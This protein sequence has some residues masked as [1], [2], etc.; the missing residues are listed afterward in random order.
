MINVNYLEETGVISTVTNPGLIDPGTIVI[1]K[2]GS[3]NVPGGDQA[4]DFPVIELDTAFL[5]HKAESNKFLGFIGDL[6][7]YE[8]KHIPEKYYYNNIYPLELLNTADQDYLGSDQ[9]LF[10]AV[11]KY[12]VFSELAGIDYKN[13]SSLSPSNYDKFKPKYFGTVLSGNRT[14]MMFMIPPGYDTAFISNSS[15]IYSYDEYFQ[16]YGVLFQEEY[17]QEAYL[18]PRVSFN[19]TRPSSGH[20]YYG[21]NVSLINSGTIDVNSHSYQEVDPNTFTSIVEQMYDTGIIDNATDP[22]LDPDPNTGGR[23]N[24]T[25][26]GVTTVSSL[27]DGYS[28]VNNSTLGLDLVLADDNLFNTEYAQVS[29]DVFN[30]DYWTP[31]SSYKFRPLRDFE[32]YFKRRT[33]LGRNSYR[34][35]KLENLLSNLTNLKEYIENRFSLESENNWLETEYLFAESNG[36]ESVY[37]IPVYINVNDTYRNLRDISKY[38]FLLDN[39]ENQLYQKITKNGNQNI[40]DVQCIEFKWNSSTGEATIT[41]SPIYGPELYQLTKEGTNYSPTSQEKIWKVDN[42]HLIRTIP[43]NSGLVDTV[44]LTKVGSDFKLSKV[45]ENMSYYK[46]FSVKEVIM[47]RDGNTNE[48]YYRINKPGWMIKVSNNTQGTTPYNPR[49]HESFIDGN[50]DINPQWNNLYGSANYYKYLTEASQLK[51][52]IV[53]SSYDDYYKLVKIVFSPEENYSIKLIEDNSGNNATLTLRPG[54]IFKIEDKIVKVDYLWEERAN[55][56]GNVILLE[57][58]PNSIEE[59]KYY[60]GTN[61]NVNGVYYSLTGYTITETTVDDESSLAIAAFGNIIVIG[62]DENNYKKYTLSIN[63]S[64]LAIESINLVNLGYKTSDNPYKNLDKYLIRDIGLVKKYE[65]DYQGVKDLTSGTYISSSIRQRENEFYVSFIKYSYRRNYKKGQIA[66]VG[67]PENLNKKIVDIQAIVPRTENLNI[68]DYSEGTILYDYFLGKVFEVKGSETISDDGTVTPGTNGNLL[69][70][71]ISDFNQLYRYKSE[72]YLLQEE[73][74]DA[75]TTFTELM[76]VGKL[77]IRTWISLSNDNVN[78]FP[79]MSKNWMSRDGNLTIG[80]KIWLMITSGNTQKRVLG[81]IARKSSTETNNIGTC[82][83]LASG[84]LE[85]DTARI[86]GVEV[87]VDN[88]SGIPQEYSGT[89]KFVYDIYMMKQVSV[90]RGKK[91]IIADITN[92]LVFRDKINYLSN[93]YES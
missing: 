10:K 66:L 15:G 72:Y 49:D 87:L 55:I 22:A 50:F 23:G 9:Q 84:Y 82:I 42:I 16:Y 89:E 25:P 20:D 68:K 56:I 74:S 86:N 75:N 14:I 79:G 19:A 1:G 8:F 57:Q 7:E 73:T 60:I 13:S 11:E 18:N 80:D 71:D 40:E 76:R 59:V 2:L 90:G 4:V 52:D 44:Q 5:Q 29:E 93:N 26:V 48:G 12:S 17:I 51:I 46:I 32:F 45:N 31:N 61:I 36:Y 3:V 38:I 28:I 33:A 91:T 83:K 69:L 88:H 6:A 63:P 78:N 37:R 39:G 21:E 81:T 85:S 47:V 30:Y 54:D 62:I 34:Y 92:N 58:I 35:F 64:S 43:V 67:L 24:G 41:K 70:E 77:G 65:K 53:D 27:M